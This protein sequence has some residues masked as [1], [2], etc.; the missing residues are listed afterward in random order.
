MGAVRPAAGACKMKARE[1]PPVDTPAPSYRCRRYPA[2]VIAHCVR[3]CYRFPLS[4][5][6]VEEPM[7]ARGAIVSHETIPSLVPGMVRDILVQEPRTREAAE[8]FLRRVVGEYPGEPRVV[9]TDT[10]ASNPP[11]REKVVPRTEHRRHEGPNHAMENSR[12]PTRQR[13]RAMRGFTS[14]AQPQRLPG[15]FGPIREH[16]CP[17]RHRLSASD[18]RA[19]LAT[20][21]GNLAR[22]GCGCLTEASSRRRRVRAGTPTPHSWAA[23][24]TEP[25]R[26]PRRC[27]GWRGDDPGVGGNAT[28][29]R[30]T[31][32]RSEASRRRGRPSATRA[33]SCP[34]YRGSRTPPGMRM[35]CGL[36]GSG[37]AGRIHE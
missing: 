35:P 13:E 24:V 19:I 26:W 31:S 29:P 32:A 36:M 10:P 22:G 9:V 17:G 8:T 6:C 12:R 37:C 28:A 7:L 3:L 4:H 34:P 16:F 1:E 2:E 20:R 33:P 11:A 25:R 21:F 5:R 15:P 23:N 30:G 18:H 27:P 14:P